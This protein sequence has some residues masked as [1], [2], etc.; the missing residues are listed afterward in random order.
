MAAG[1]IRVIQ[2]GTRPRYY[3]IPAHEVLGCEGHHEAVPY[4]SEAAAKPQWIWLPNTIVDGAANETTPLEILRQSQN[5]TALRIFGDLY[6]AH[7]L[8]S[9]GGADWRPDKGSLF[10]LIIS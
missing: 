3:I 8:A 10:V 1:L 4:N 9:D 7:T 5:T 6:H 2:G